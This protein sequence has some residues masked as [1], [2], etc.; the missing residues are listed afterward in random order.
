MYANFLGTYRAI[1]T[2]NV[3]PT[4][5]GFIKV[6]C[7]QVAGLAELNAAEPA[8]KDA[9]IPNL[10]DIVW[11]YFNGGET[12]KPVY[13]VTKDPNV[14]HTPTLSTNWNFSSSVVGFG[15]GVG[16]RYRRM[17]DNT[18]WLSGLVSP[19]AGAGTT[20]CTLPPGFYNPN[21]NYLNAIYNDYSGDIGM[22]VERTTGNVYVQNVQVGANYVFDHRMS[23][24]I[25]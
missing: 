19:S 20:V 6:Q 21:T 13:R 25:T 18:V 9:P 24:D 23:L 4:N 12:H 1:V 11:I 10:G 7:P 17:P 8:D 22:A 15:N 2:N 3:D 5:R 16:L 14:W